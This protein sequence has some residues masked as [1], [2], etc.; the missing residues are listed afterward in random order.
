MHY[1]SRSLNWKNA[2]QS[3]HGARLIRDCWLLPKTQSL[4]ARP[5]TSKVLLA[6][7]SQETVSTSTLNNKTWLP[8]GCSNR[9]PWTNEHRL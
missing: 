5:Y 7:H 6:D 4:M 3:K 9:S 2:T 1:A 8:H